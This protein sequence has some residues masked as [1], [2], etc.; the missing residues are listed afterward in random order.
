MPSPKPIETRYKGYRFRS[1]LEARWAVFFDALGIPWEYEREGFD[2]DGVPYL[3][4]FYLFENDRA[5]WLEVKPESPT[6]E[7][8]DKVRRLVKATRQLAVIVEGPPSQDPYGI[9][10]AERFSWGDLDD[11]WLKMMAEDPEEFGGQAAVAEK[12]KLR[13]MVWQMC[14]MTFNDLFSG[15]IHKLPTE[16]EVAVHAARSARWGHGEHGPR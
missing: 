7:E 2:L 12:V 6:N 16:Y 5:F 1:R 3:P 4:D 10:S 14:I 11:D 8:R 9:V 15:R 13:G